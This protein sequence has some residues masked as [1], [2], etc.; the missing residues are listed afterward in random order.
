VS[1]QYVQSDFFVGAGDLIVEGKW[2]HITGEPF[3]SSMSALVNFEPF[4]Q[5]GFV[6]NLDILVATFNSSGRLVLRQAAISEP[7]QG[8]L[9]EKPVGNAAGP[10]L[11]GYALFFG[12]CNKF[13]SSGHIVGSIVTTTSRGSYFSTVTLPTSLSSDTTTSLEIASTPLIAD[14]TTNAV[15]SEVSTA[16]ESGSEQITTDVLTTPTV[17]VGEWG[18]WGS[19]EMDM[20]EF[21]YG[22]GVTGETRFRG[23]VDKNDPDNIEPLC[24]GNSSE[25]ARVTLTYP[26][27]DPVPLFGASFD[28][29]K[30]ACRTAGL[31]AFTALDEFCDGTPQLIDSLKDTRFWTGLKADEDI[32]GTPFQ[33]L[34]YNDD[35]DADYFNNTFVYLH[36]QSKISENFLSDFIMGNRCV[37]INASGILDLADCTWDAIDSYAICDRTVVV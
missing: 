24:V 30:D 12:V 21:C 10:C 35:G 25:A 28:A 36:S 17:G 20:A 7:T 2:Q 1:S 3:D 14:S 29:N 31:T 26:G 11:K 9:C 16:T 34:L 4:G 27:P 15:T 13:N 18:D 5:S 19:W 8:V 23:C 33:L 32:K 22:F 37:L 6:A